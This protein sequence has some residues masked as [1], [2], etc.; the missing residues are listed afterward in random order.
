MGA[1]SCCAQVENA[2]SH[3]NQ[4]LCGKQ[5]WKNTSDTGKK[6]PIF[7][8]ESIPSICVSANRFRWSMELSQIWMFEYQTRKHVHVCAHIHALRLDKNE[9]SRACSH[10]GRAST[11][12]RWMNPN[13]HRF[14]SVFGFFE[15]QVISLIVKAIFF[16]P[17]IHVSYSIDSKGHDSVNSFIRNLLFIPSMELML[18]INRIQ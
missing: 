6:C 18:N 16:S 14:V 12:L 5:A 1:S 15:K 4:L 17:V 11:N 2:D 13:P 3:A 10:Y 8:Q 7:T 9:Y